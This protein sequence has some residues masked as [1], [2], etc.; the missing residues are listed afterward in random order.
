MKRFE[1]YK[2]IRKQAVIF[3]LPIS[4]FALMMMSILASLMVIIFSFSFGMIIGIFIFNAVLYV[5]LTRIT[6]NP[7]LFQMEK[8]FPEIISNKRNT[9]FDYE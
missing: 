1:V 8:V 6:N 3:G 5:A 7:Q 2:N 9:G 4:L